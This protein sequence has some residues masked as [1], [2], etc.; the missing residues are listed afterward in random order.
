MKFHLDAL[1]IRGVLKIVVLKP[2]ANQKQSALRAYKKLIQ[3]RV[4]GFGL[5]DAVVGWMALRQR[6]IPSDFVI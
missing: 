5:K 3:T 2:V 6:C 4:Q 1:Q